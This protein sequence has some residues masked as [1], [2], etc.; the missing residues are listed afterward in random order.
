MDIESKT[1]IYEEKEETQEVNPEEQKS[2]INSEKEKEK[3]I[4]TRCL[5]R[6]SAQRKSIFFSGK[7]RS[8]GTPPY[9]AATWL[10]GRGR[11]ALPLKKS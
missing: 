4:D 10:H 2:E 3:D 6:R 9:L 5:A 11:A 8:A 1:S 7:G